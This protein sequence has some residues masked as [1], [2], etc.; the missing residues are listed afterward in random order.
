MKVIVKYPSREPET[1]E[2]PH[3]LEAFQAIVGGYIECVPFPYKDAL[4]ICNE[5]GKLKG[6]EPN[7]IIG[8]EVIVGPVVIC[9]QDGDEFADVPFEVD[10][11]W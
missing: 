2:I 3:E 8:R 7:L 11:L 10:E 1:R 4:L 5:E 6:M 9:G